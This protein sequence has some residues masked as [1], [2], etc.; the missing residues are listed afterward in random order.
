M[1]TVLC[2]GGLDPSGGAGLSADI[3]ALAFLNVD[4]L[5]VAS[6]LTAQ[7]SKKFYSL[8]PV[9]PKSFEKALDSAI[10]E[11]KPD[12]F[13]SGLLGSVENVKLLASFIKKRKAPFVLDPVFKSSTGHSFADKNIIDAYKRLLFPLATVVTPNAD[14]ASALT[15]R[16]IAT[17]EDA[18]DTIK[19]ISNLGPKAVIIKGGHFTREKGSDIMYFGK[20]LYVYKMS[21]YPSAPR[22][23]G[24]TYASLIAGYLALGLKVPDAVGRSKVDMVRVFNFSQADRPVPVKFY[25]GL[26]GERRE[27][28]LAVQKAAS[29]ALTVLTPE[30][31]PEV[32]VNM[33]FALKSAKGLG[34]VCTLDS[35]IVLKGKRPVT[36]GT[37]VFG[38]DSHVARV[39]LAA[40][41]RDR[42]SRAAMNLKY[43]DTFINIIRNMGLRAVSF[44]RSEE[45]R[46]KSTMEWGTG[47]AF[48]ALGR[49]PDAIFDLGAKGK[50]PMI[51]LLAKDPE[52]L[53]EKLRDILEI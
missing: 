15:G 3:K 43:S 38:R 12:A 10:E 1:A 42:N 47:R 27:V 34:D 18:C 40:V 7:N 22:G 31:M 14:E 25:V 37:P 5:P 17:R 26:S 23:T 39:I 46:K 30:L 51:R 8:E 2:A 32:G 35:R 28:W 16:R 11:A 21:E 33:G 6:A 24:C 9:S 29:E 4:C 52:H 48:E 44:E 19:A 50:E 13:K 49:T 20:K 53:L 45:P 36:F 41:K